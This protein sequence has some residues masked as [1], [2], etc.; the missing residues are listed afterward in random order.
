VLFTSGYPSDSVIRERIA[1]GRAGFIQKP[2]LAD[3]LARAIRKT[4]EDANH[5]DD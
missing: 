3:E 4:L 1:E 5:T 2:F